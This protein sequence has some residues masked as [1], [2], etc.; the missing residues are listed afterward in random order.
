MTRFATWTTLACVVLLA[1][2]CQTRA[3]ASSCDGWRRLTPAAQ[4]R[5]FVIAQDRPFAEQVA[6]HNAFGVNRGCWK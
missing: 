2:G 6:A 1:A 5:T 4:T 3:P